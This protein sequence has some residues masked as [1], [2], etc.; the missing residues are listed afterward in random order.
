MH[1]VPQPRLTLPA[2]AGRLERGVR[3]HF[4]ATEILGFWY[5]VLGA[6]SQSSPANLEVRLAC[7]CGVIVGPPPSEFAGTFHRLEREDAA[8][9]VVAVPDMYQAI[10]LAGEERSTDACEGARG[11]IRLVYLERM[12]SPSL[13][14]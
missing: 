2:V 8:T 12:F 3:R 10:G 4:A 9:I 13:A 14:V 6:H 1:Q 7:R 11:F 5:V